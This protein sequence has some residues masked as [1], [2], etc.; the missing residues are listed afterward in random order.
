MMIVHLNGLAVKGL[1]DTG[2]DVTVITETEALGFPHWKFRPAPSNS[3]EEGQKN[4]CTTVC[5]LHWKDID[6]NQG[7]LF[8][9]MAHVP[10]NLWWQDIL[11]DKG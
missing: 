1:V 8:P 10:H 4:T 7:S 6:G 5:P 3:R 11:M 2:V 9:V